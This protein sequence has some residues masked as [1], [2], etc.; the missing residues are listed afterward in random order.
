[1]IIKIGCCYR[2]LIAEEREEISRSLAKGESFQAIASYLGRSVST[3]AREVTRGGCNRWTYRADRAQRQS[4]RNARRRPLGKRKIFLNH[5]LREYVQKKLSLCWSPQQIARR[6]EIRYPLDMSMRISHEAIDAYVY[7]L[8]KGT[9]KKELISGFRRS[10]KRRYRKGK[11]AVKSRP[12]TDMVSIDERPSEVEGW[13]VPGHWEGDLMIGR[14]RQSALGTLT[15]RTS[16]LGLLIR[17]RGKSAEE[18]RKKFARK[19]KRL[20]QHARLSLT[21]DQG[22]EMS[23]HAILTADTKIRVYFAHKG[24]PWERGTNENF[25]GLVRQFFPKGTDFNKVSNDHINKVQ[26]MLNGRPRR[27]LNWQTP[28]EAFTKIV[29][30]KA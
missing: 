17:L 22:R 24:C 28:Y 27:V 15:E 7:V 8:P 2:R 21:Y 10:H 5:Q 18:I 16:R 12:F 23:E 1:M 9:L 4:W 19:L 29:A 11:E 14:N 13:M 30:L 25:N 3:I 26:N 20:P 6:I